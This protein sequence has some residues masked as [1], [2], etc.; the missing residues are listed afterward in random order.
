MGRISWVVP[1]NIKITCYDMAMKRETEQFI[2]LLSPLIPFSV[3]GWFSESQRGVYLMISAKKNKGMKYIKKFAFNLLI[4]HQASTL[5]T[6][7]DQ[8]LNGV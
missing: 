4:V 2:I 5:C 3:G 1:Q 8:K 7:K 6:F